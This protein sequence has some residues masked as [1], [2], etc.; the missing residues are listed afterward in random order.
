MS[1]YIPPQASLAKVSYERLPETLLEMLERDLP[2]Y[3]SVEGIPEEYFTYAENEFERKLYQHMKR[4]N[5]SLRLGK[6]KKGL[7]STIYPGKL[8]LLSSFAEMPRVLEDMYQGHRA[9]ALSSNQLQLDYYKLFLMGHE[10]EEYPLTDVKE[11]CESM[12]GYFS[13][14]LKCQFKPSGT[15]PCTCTGSCADIRPKTGCWRTS[16]DA[17]GT[18]GSW[19]SC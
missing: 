14:L 19:T 4:K 17:C 9:F 5:S 15:G 10:G 16:W 6:V 13:P 1:I 18:R 7:V 12:R 3:L 2:V 8:C 11:R